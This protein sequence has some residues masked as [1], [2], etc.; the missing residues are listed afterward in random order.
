[1]L[2]SPPKVTAGAAP[3]PPPVGGVRRDP[4]APCLPHDL[5]TIAEEPSGPLSPHGGKD[6][7]AISGLSAS[8]APAITLPACG[9]CSHCGCADARPLVEVSKTL[10]MMLGS[11]IPPAHHT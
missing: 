3:R 6:C 4:K 8:A 2:A 5:P 10:G 9:N 7:P 11:R 1:M